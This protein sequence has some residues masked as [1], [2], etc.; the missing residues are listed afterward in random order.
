MR[1]RY[2]V[3]A[4]LQRMRMRILAT[5]AARGRHGTDCR[6]GIIEC[7]LMMNRSTFTAQVSLMSRL[8][9]LER[10]EGRRN[11]ARETLYVITA[12]GRKY[13]SDELARIEAECAHIQDIMGWLDD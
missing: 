8:G 7:G 10:Y 13:L 2:K 9:Y 3:E 1:A 12:K 11:D 4:R 6:R 5:I